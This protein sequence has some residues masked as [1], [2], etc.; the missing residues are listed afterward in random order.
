MSTRCAAEFDR[1]GPV[2]AT[3]TPR[4]M[5][6]GG[7]G[8][9]PSSL[10]DA[11]RMRDSRLKRKTAKSSASAVRAAARRKAKADEAARAKLL[12]REAR[13]P[14][15]DVAPSLRLSSVREEVLA[16]S[17]RH[18]ARTAV[19][20]DR[21]R[22]WAPNRKSVTEVVGTDDRKLYGVSYDHMLPL[23]RFLAPQLASAFGHKIAARPCTDDL[24]AENQCAPRRTRA[25]VA[26]S[27]RGK[28]GSSTQK[29]PSQSRG[30]S[31]I[32]TGN[33]KSSSG[34]HRDAT[35]TLL[36]CVSGDRT[37]WFAK[38]DESNDTT[39]R[40]LDMVYAG[41][42]AFLPR[43][44]DPS[45]PLA[46][47]KKGAPRWAQPV[48]LTT[49]D[50]MWIKSGWWHCIVS[51]PDAVAVAIEVEIEMVGGA[52]PCVWRGVGPD[53]VIRRDGRRVCRAQGW[54]SGAS[55]RAMW[56]PWSPLAL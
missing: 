42:P 49:G 38:P 3:A 1:V 32:T 22:A 13:P 8:P 24:V 41:S 33:Q 53:R 11:V 25:E 45:T 9:K 26:K 39:D 14:P 5:P 43:L 51:E 29:K 35:D 16:A 31:I 46:S 4:Q 34:P 44:F 12:A 47:K 36:L 2:F 50:A 52:T 27:E 28:P 55:V 15:R 23:L 48:T 56:D 30:G 6:S 54:S 19:E 37:V 17:H 18:R 40:D 21:H 10:P 20:R 7:V